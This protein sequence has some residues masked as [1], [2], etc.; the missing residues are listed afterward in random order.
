M[1]LLAPHRLDTETGA[2]VLFDPSAEDPDRRI[3]LFL[4]PAI[5]RWSAGR[6][7]APLD[8]SLKTTTG[9]ASIARTDSLP[10]RLT[11]AARRTRRLACLHSVR[12]L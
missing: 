4:R 7:R 12:P 8:S 5:P 10:A 3:S 1:L 6:V 2:A 11:E 9:F